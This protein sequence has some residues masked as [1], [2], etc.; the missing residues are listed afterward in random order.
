[1][2]QEDVVAQIQKSANTP[3]VFQIERAGTPMDVTVVPDLKGKIGVVGLS[4][5]SYETRRVDPNLWTAMRMSLSENW[6]S[7]QLITT[8]LAGLFTTETPVT[9]LV[10]PVGIAQMSG[11][12]GQAWLD[13]FAGPDGDD[14]PPAGAAESPAHSRPRRRAHYDHPARGLARRDFS[15]CSR[16]ASSSRDSR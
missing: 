16:N 15:A 8:T 9:N 5:A 3:L 1:M 12:D 7:A 14:Q 10:G 4:I 13:S 11:P 2:R 6:Q